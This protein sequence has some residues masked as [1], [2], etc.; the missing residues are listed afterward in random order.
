MFASL[1]CL[2]LAIPGIVE[3]TPVQWLENGHYYEFIAV[4]DGLTWEDAN[5]SADSAIYQGMTGHL[6]TITSQAENV[7]L[8]SMASVQDGWYWIG[9]TMEQ[10]N[11]ADQFADWAWVTGEDFTYMNPQY[12]SPFSMNGVDGVPF[13]LAL[14][15]AQGSAY[16]GEWNDV[17]A[18]DTAGNPGY[19]VEYEPVIPEPST[20]ILVGV[21]LISLLGLRRVY[22]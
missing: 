17:I 2:F 13:A 18:T 12:G 10:W 1:L 5:A 6:V 16:H 20:L 9:A 21:G 8:E 11:G 3:A 14:L 4:E 15:M 22:T 7:F 19:I